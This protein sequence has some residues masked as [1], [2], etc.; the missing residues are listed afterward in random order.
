MGKYV[1]KIIK[2]YVKGENHWHYKGGFITDKDGYIKARAP[3]HS[4]ADPWGYVWQ[5]V[6]VFEEHQHCCMLKWG[7][8]H[9]KDENPKNNTWKNLEG[10]T[11]GQHSRHHRTGKEW[12]DEVKKKIAL[13][14]NENRF[15]KGH[16]PWNKKGA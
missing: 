5:H 1:K 14:D 6:L 3:H 12:S 10:M 16:V 8:V 9:H 2:S 11:K 13:K 4:R 7:I 15:K